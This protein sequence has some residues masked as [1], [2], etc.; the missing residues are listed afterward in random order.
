MFNL[1]VKIAM[2]PCLF[3]PMNVENSLQKNDLQINKP[4]IK[5]I[6]EFVHTLNR[7]WYTYTKRLEVTER[8]PIKG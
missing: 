6:K 7:P 8:M 2:C 5:Y 1:P 4:F 3:I